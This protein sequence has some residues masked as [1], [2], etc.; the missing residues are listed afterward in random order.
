MTNDPFQGNALCPPEGVAKPAAECRDDYIESTFEP[1]IETGDFA[2]LA[3][4]IRNYHDRSDHY[5]S[6]SRL[7]V[8]D[9]MQE[10]LLRT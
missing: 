5:S 2:E 8:F 3:Y 4:N 1:P 9:H 10:L 6:T 7:E